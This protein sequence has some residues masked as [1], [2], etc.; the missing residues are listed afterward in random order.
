MAPCEDGSE[1]RKRHGCLRSPWPRRPPQ[2]DRAQQVVAL[3][4]LGGRAVEA[5]VPALD[6]EGVPARL[7]ARFTLCSTRITVVAVGVDPADDA[8]Q[9]VDGHGRQAEG[10]LVDHQQLGLGHHHP[11]QGEHLLLAPRERA[12]RLVEAA[13][14]SGNASSGLS[15]ARRGGAGAVANE[16]VAADAEVV[17]HREAGEGHLPAHQQGHALVDDLLGFEV[18][19][20]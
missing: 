6:E 18:G 15:T 12:G 17:P 19:A 9:P 2:E 10:Q 3:E 14:S 16:Y 1:R 13:A 11:G 8:H 5:D 7:M 4:Q 20:S